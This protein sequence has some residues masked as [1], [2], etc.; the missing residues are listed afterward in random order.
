[1]RRRIPMLSSPPLCAH[2]YVMERKRSHVSQLG[3]QESED[4]MA[5]SD[6]RFREND[7]VATA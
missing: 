1:M 2:G 5:L 7:T 3:L 4:E 6:F